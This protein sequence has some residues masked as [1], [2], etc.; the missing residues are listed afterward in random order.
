[1]LHFIRERAKGFFA[2]LI[3]VMI[4]VPFAFWGI[5]SYFGNG[6]VVSVAE[7]NGVK[8][9]SQEFQ[10]LFVQERNFRQRL[11]GKV[12]NPALLNEALIKRAVLDKLINTAALAQAAE[13]AG[14]RI[15]DRQLSRQIV[16]T[17]QF[18]RDG[19]FD[20]QRYAQ[21][22]NSMGLTE[23]AYEEELRRDMLVDQLIS[24]LTESGFVTRKALDNALRLQK[25]Q[26]KFGYL[27]L[28]ASRFIDEKAALPESRI[29]SYYDDHQDR[30]VI[31]EKVSIAYLE[32]SASDLVKQVKVDDE[33]LRKMYEEQQSQLAMGE[34]RRASH[35]LIPVEE[36]ADE[37]TDKAARNKALD[38]L[39]QLRAG[40]SFK[41]LA[42]KFSGD[43][44][45]AAKGG[46]LGFFSH[47]MMVKPFEDSV[48]SMAVGDISEP[49]RTPFG[50]HIIKLTGIRKSAAQSFEKMRDAL[51]KE[52]REQQA[53]EQFYD[54]ADRIADLTYE[55]PDNL[56]IASR[57]LGLPVKKSTLFDRQHG[58][59]I[60]SD[61]KVRAAAFSSDVLDSGN[62]SEPIMLAP[63]HL[64]VLRVDKHE[65]LSH[66]PLAAVHDDIVAVLRLE[67]ARKRA[68]KKS[69]EILAQLLKGKSPA[70]L[71][72]KEGVQWHVSSFID[73][74][75]KKVPEDIISAAFK[76]PRPEKEAAAT[77]DA[78][79]LPDGNAAVILL[80]AVRDGNPA[81]LGQQVRKAEEKQI[82]QR[83]GQ[84]ISH[85]VIEA[86]KKRAEI[87]VHQEKL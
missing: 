33:V 26:R 43:P 18:L 73:R 72:A 41:A 8:I 69:R 22:L 85:A 7:V 17:Q 16:R 30:Y 58:S 37:Q 48:Y 40:A 50:Y 52:Y 77:G 76:L 61:A 12:G 36:G 1:M 39:K 29:K 78:L 51:A 38:I 24:G 42:K 62:N 35:I 31:P 81:K 34:E 56:E 70:R 25:Q 86:I 71:A 23:G 57:E 5:N 2:W 67:D 6:G 10:R 47:G 49:V 28:K 80:Q 20:P 79:Q 82:L 14:F 11:F 55:N 75:D 9:D 19:R 83:R 68:E 13:D 27:V 45:S 63:N 84:Q 74:D 65:P 15:S 54:M 60:G 87:V 32:L 53:E 21:V 59:G 64:I 66:R 3:F 46:D 4:V 44:E